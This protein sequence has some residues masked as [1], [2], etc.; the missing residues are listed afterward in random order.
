[1]IVPYTRFLS[2]LVNGI[3]RSY[4]SNLYGIKEDLEFDF[5]QYILCHMQLG[6]LCHL[7]KRELYTIHQV[8]KWVEKGINVDLFQIVTVLQWYYLDMARFF[9]CL[10]RHCILEGKRVSVNAPVETLMSLGVKETEIDFLLE[11]E[12]VF[13]S[14]RTGKGAYAPYINLGYKEFVDF[15]SIFQSEE[16]KSR[17]AMSM[18][19]TK[20]S[21]NK[22]VIRWKNM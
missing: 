22:E 1:M 13:T 15:E 9:Q 10:S 12:M 3:N 2:F 19:L 11:K 18:V 17:F 4:R 14:L 7:Q 20:I 5:E 6:T 16:Q 21:E 8:Y